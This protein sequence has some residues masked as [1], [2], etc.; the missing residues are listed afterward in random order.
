M[1]H[2]EVRKTS[3]YLGIEQ[4]DAG[5]GAFRVGGRVLLVYIPPICQP[6]ANHFGTSLQCAGFGTSQIALIAPTCRTSKSERPLRTWGLN[7]GRLETEFPKVS[8][9]IPDDPVSMLLEKV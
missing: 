6:E 1:P 8:P 4:R 5:S 2:I 7:S 9:A 3:A